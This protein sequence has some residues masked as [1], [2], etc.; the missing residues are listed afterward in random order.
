MKVLLT[1][2]VFLL[3]QNTQSPTLLGQF[4]Y[5]KKKQKIFSSYLFS[6][7]MRFISI[8]S[9]DVASLYGNGHYEIVNGNLI[10]H[11]H[12]QEKEGALP[13]GYQRVPTSVDTIPISFIGKKRLKLYCEMTGSME[14]YKK[15]RAQ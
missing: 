1:I 10:L 12:P 9:G 13:E 2:V 5:E 14:V 3:F 7:G 11:Y 15:V 8:N 6:P 4:T